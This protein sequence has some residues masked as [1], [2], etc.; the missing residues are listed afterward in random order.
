MS[1]AESED[2]APLLEHLIELRRRLLWSLA[3]LLIAFLGSW[4][5]AAEIFNFLAQ[6][7]ADAFGDQEGAQLIYTS[8]PEKFF[9]NIKI[10]FYTALFISFPIIANQ[11]WKFVAPGLYK[12][13]KGAFLPY[14][15]ATPILFFL[16]GA[17]VYFGIFPLA[18][19]FFLGYQ[20]V[21][22]DPNAAGVVIETVAMPKVSEYLSLVITLIF[23]FG[24][25]FQM[26]VVL[27]LLAHAGIVSAD[28]LAKKRKYAVV[29]MFGLA[30]VLTPPDVI[31]Q[32]GLAVP[33][34][35]LYE[36]SILLAQRIERKR[37]SYFDDD[38][39]AKDN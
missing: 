20:D 27:T 2:K 14:L 12:N 24:L 26:P 4:A 33:G 36:I 13:E 28:G 1:G 22:G 8:L 29:A 32:I 7:L 39:D 19:K 17:V 11:I 6:P 5:V 18:W 30:A 35:L 31:S 34:L 37:E 21:A 10:A 15:A 23:A 3:A 9:V 16:G 38:D 25:F